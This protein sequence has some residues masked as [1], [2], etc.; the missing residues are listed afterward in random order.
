M[1]HGC[2]YCD[3]SGATIPAVVLVSLGKCEVVQAH[4]K[5]LAI[6]SPQSCPDYVAND[7]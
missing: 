5:C 7:Y 3:E 4:Y 6:H 2:F 1:P